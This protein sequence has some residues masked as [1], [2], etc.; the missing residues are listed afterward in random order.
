MCADFISGKASSTQRSATFSS[1]GAAF[2]IFVEGL[3]KFRS[4][5]GNETFLN[6]KA[7]SGIRSEMDY[8]CISPYN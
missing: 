6:L 1:S 7:V 5:T 8:S 4:W 3:R 2:R